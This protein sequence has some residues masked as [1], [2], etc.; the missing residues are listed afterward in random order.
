MTKLIA[1]IS[2]IVSAV[3]GIGSLIFNYLTYTNER[4]VEII[5]KNPIP[6]VIKEEDDKGKR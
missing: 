5:N 3:V 6:A 2:I 4:K 1:I